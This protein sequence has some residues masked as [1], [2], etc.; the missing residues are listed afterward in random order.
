MPVSLTKRRVMGMPST[1]P[2]FKAWA[3]LI[4]L[5]ILCTVVAYLL[6]FR[7]IGNLGA[8]EAIAVTSLMLVF[9]MLWGWL[10][11]HEPIAG[12]MLVA[13]A[14]ILTGTALT[15]GLIKLARQPRPAPKA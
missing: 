7:L 9:G 1:V 5:G 3:S 4:A 15:T 13:T 6:Y 11:L 8:T 2:G 10:S 14:I 12:Q